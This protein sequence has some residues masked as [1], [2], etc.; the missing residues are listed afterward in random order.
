MS[1]INQVKEA[2]DIIALINERVP[3]Q[4]SGLNYRANCPFHGE[5]T[6]SFFVNETIQRYKC[7]GCGESGDVFTFLEKYEGMSFAESLQYLA[8]QAGITLKKMARSPED[9]QR[10]KLL[11]ILNLAKEYYHYLLQKHPAGE[12]ARSY[13]KERGITSES[14]KVFQIGAAADSW[15]SLLKYLTK[16]KKYP[17]ELLDAAGLVVKGKA[18][19]YY[20][21]FRNRVVFPLTNH[22]GQ[23]VGFSGR[24]LEKDPKSAKYINSPETS[25][26]HKSE[27]LFGYSHLRKAIR[28]QQT[29]IVTEGELDVVSSAQAHV[30]NV[31]GLKGSALT[32]QQAKLLERVASKVILALD[33]D[34]A[35]IEATK[36]AIGVSAERSYELRVVMLPE[37]KDPDQLAQKKPDVWR[38]TVK[39]SVSVTD[40]FLTVLQKQHDVSTP[41][42]KREI[43]KEITPVLQSITHA[44]EQDFYIKKVAKVLGVRESVVREDLR[45]ASN[46][47]G[48]APVRKVQEETAQPV[49]KMTD[50]LS[51]IER[52]LLRVLLLQENKIPERLAAISWQQM[53]DGLFKSLIVQ[54]A[55]FVQKKSGQAGDFTLGSWPRSLAADHQQLIL[56][57]LADP[58]WDDANADELE[59]IW[60]QLKQRLVKEMTQQKINAITQELNELDSIEDKAPEQEKRQQEL[61]QQVVQLRVK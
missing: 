26:Y 10:E 19:R 36:R 1:Q 4:R 16:K 52:Q 14:V 24:T 30:N 55:D 18:G 29:V 25:L 17:V 46:R 42:G 56:E 15:D 35:G 39:E 59:K 49:E 12:A 20:D 53:T 27:L 50:K 9:D 28:E 54:L 58:E 5:K 40:F 22:R 34:K 43:M 11:A 23:V 32:E 37:G 8:D 41:E 61:L 6:P 7:F 48:K 51:T 57:I 60:S 38:K 2:T 47:K 21:R 13:V 44:V 31:V 45:R 3:L 33:T